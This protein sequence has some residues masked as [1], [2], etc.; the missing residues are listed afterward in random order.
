M[1]QINNLM[2]GSA[3]AVNPPANPPPGASTGQ[4]VATIPGINPAITDALANPVNN[5]GTLA[6]R[7][8]GAY[9][10]CAHPRANNWETLQQ[11]KIAEGDFY[12]DGCG[13]LRKCMPLAYWVMQVS[14]FGTAM[15]PA[16][17]VVNAT[18]NQD[19]I[20]NPGQLKNAGMQEHY[21][22]LVL[23]N[24]GDR[25]VPAKADFR[26]TRAD[27][28]KVPVAELRK[29]AEPNWPQSSDAAR[30]AAAFPHP[31]G[32]VYFS[33]TTVKGVVKGGPNKGLPYHAARIT[34]VP[35][36]VGELDKLTK[37]IQSPGFA[38]LVN[39]A[40]QNYSARCDM[41]RAACPK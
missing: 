5:V 17:D 36:P 12:I 11:A 8:V 7:P 28:G 4:A 6:E 19:I 20:A 14:R 9:V 24:L 37:A 29:V 40:W 22:T 32:R 1:P 3:P 10:G 41:I 23:V 26:G 16:G 33:A 21:V 27:G 31:F 13:E 25:I 39:Q 15:S 30:V 38:E 34:A 18:E 35:T 2:A